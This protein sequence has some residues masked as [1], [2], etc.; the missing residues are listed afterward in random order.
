MKSFNGRSPMPCSRVFDN[1][2]PNSPSSSSRVSSALFIACRCS[3]SCNRKFVSV[4]RSISHM[5]NAPSWPSR[6]NSWCAR[7]ASTRGNR[8]CM[9]SAAMPASNTLLMT[10]SSRST[11]PIGLIQ[12]R[13]RAI[14]IRRRQSVISPLPI[15]ANT[16]SIVFGMTRSSSAYQFSTVK[17]LKLRLLEAVCRRATRPSTTRQ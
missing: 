4:S 6:T 9:T 14:A 5:V 13:M 12:S 17:C 2:S 16:M 11:A 1:M 10:P 8:F 15:P 3:S 7:H